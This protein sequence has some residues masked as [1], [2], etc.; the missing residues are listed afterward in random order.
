M[1]LSLRRDEGGFNQHSTYKLGGA[2][3][4]SIGRGTAA[5]RG[6]STVG[7]AGA[8]AGHTRLGRR[9]R[10]SRARD[11]SRAA[12]ATGVGQAVECHGAWASSEA[13]DGG[14]AAASG[15]TM[16]ANYACD[17]RV[18]RSGAS[19]GM[20][21]EGARVVARPMYVATTRGGRMSGTF[22]QSCGGI[23]G[24]PSTGVMAAEPA[25][26]AEWRRRRRGRET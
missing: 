3:A 4:P 25:G 11:A 12:A 16:T 7:E 1:S 17:S 8:G 5:C 6:E 23:G 21:D 10:P 18:S 19:V 13:A 15:T 9:S 2:G 24:R 22:R 20:G 26:A 14:T